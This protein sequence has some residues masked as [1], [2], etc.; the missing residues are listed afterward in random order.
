MKLNKVA[1]LPENFLQRSPYNT[2]FGLKDSNKTRR[3]WDCEN[4]FVKSSQKCL[5]LP[6][7]S[8]LAWTLARR[9][10][11]FRASRTNDGV[12]MASPILVTRVWVFEGQG[13]PNN[14]HKATCF[15]G[16]VGELWLSKISCCKCFEAQP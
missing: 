3:C 6:G 1:D 9:F 5:T 14:I 8:N 2:F 15:A 10:P 7:L 4:S 16:V 13:S 11:N 12:P